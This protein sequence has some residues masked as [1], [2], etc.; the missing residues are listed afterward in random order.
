MMRIIN[1]TKNTIL[2]EDAFEAKSLK[3]KTFGLIDPS[4]PRSLILHTRLGI[5]TLGMKHDIDVLI[6]GDDHKVVKLREN[7]KPGEIFNW[8]PRHSMV[9]ELPP[10]T[11]SRTKTQLGDRITLV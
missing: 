1:K 11:I 7:M 2:T 10:G 4:K 8:N 6:L 9:I 3:D 5:H